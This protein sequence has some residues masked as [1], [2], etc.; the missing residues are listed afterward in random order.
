M[1]KAVK[2]LGLC[3][4]LTT[5]TNCVHEEYFEE[6]TILEEKGSILYKIETNQTL[7]ENDNYNLTVKTDDGIYYINVKNTYKK[8]L[9]LFAKSIKEG[10]KI[11]FK[12][13]YKSDGITNYFSEDKIGN[14]K[15][16]D[17]IKINK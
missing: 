9:E 15:T 16:E 13:G 14:V 4:L 11:K 1:K 12:T 5:T 3:A 2:I 7:S 6:G 10:D 17:I 8:P